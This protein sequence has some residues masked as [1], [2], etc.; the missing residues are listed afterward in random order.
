VSL[1]DVSRIAQSFHPTPSHAAT[2]EAKAA[3]ISLVPFL[4]SFDDPSATGFIKE[5][6]LCYFM[7]ALLMV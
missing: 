4:F 6:E 5:R 7:A 2:A 3:D 1:S